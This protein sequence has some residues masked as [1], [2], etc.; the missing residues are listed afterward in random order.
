MTQLD[1]FAPP[2]A[3][4]QPFS[5]HVVCHHCDP[6]RVLAVIPVDDRPPGSWPPGNTWHAASCWAYVAHVGHLRD[7]H[8][9]HAP[10]EPS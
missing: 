2:P 10:P 7:A 5:F 9:E 4:D 3:D 1:L 8:P 6:P